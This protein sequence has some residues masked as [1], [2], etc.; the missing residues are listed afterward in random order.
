M[1]LPARGVDPPAAFLPEEPSRPPL[2]ARVNPVRPRMEDG[3]PHRIDAC[4]ARRGREDSKGTGP[5]HPPDPL[6]RIRLRNESVE[7]CQ[8]GFGRGSEAKDPHLAS[9]GRASDFRPARGFVGANGRRRR[10][11]DYRCSSGVEPIGPR[12][13]RGDRSRNSGKRELHA[14]IVRDPGSDRRP[15]RPARKSSAKVPVALP[16]SR[17]RSYFRGISRWPREE[18]NLRARIRS[19]SLYPLSYGAVRRSV[20]ASKARSKRREGG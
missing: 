19:P 16:G 14:V 4:A 5:C 12:D 10:A 7:S 1:R 6:Q 17:R 3:S 8:R 18:S 13:E 2:S 11:C 15:C 20:A 9:I